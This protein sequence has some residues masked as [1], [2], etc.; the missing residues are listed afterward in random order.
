LSSESPAPLLWPPFNDHFLCRVKLDGIA[1]LRVQDS[2]KVAF[3]SAERQI[4]HRRRDP[5]VDPH[6]PGRNLVAEFAR[7]SA[8][9]GKMCDFFEFARKA[10]LKTKDLCASKWPKNQKS[11]RL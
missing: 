2:G 11:H 3:L 7:R 5:D 1:S 4:R 6:V 8:A 9:R 10:A